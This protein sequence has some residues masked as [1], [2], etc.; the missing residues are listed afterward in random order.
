MATAFSVLI[1]VVSLIVGT[2]LGAWL[3]HR[4]TLKLLNIQNTQ[5]EKERAE[6]RDAKR[7][8]ENQAWFENYAITQCI[9]PLLTKF[10]FFKTL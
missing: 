10:Y 2:W 6:E 4:N 7:R 1:P 8:A 5:R 9:D 3:S